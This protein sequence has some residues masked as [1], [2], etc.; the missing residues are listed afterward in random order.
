VGRSS[1]RSR[2]AREED[3]GRRVNLM[4]LGSVRMRNYQ[5]YKAHA[6]RP[7]G[8][9]PEGLHR[10]ASTR[11]SSNEV[12]RGAK[13]GDAGQDQQRHCASYAA[14]QTISREMTAHGS[15]LPRYVQSVNCCGLPWFRSSSA[16][17]PGSKRWCIPR[18]WLERWR[19]LA[20]FTGSL[21][22]QR[23]GVSRVATG[24]WRGRAA[25]Q[26]TVP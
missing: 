1:A 26:N 2:A 6:L 24:A 12:T 3:G 14:P 11:R 7:G 18:P 20:T 13:Y 17:A 5:G 4:R 16:P 10:P 9:M 25:S 15:G 22:R 21:P 19:A 23:I 8:M